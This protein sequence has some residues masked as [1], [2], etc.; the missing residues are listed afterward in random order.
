MA[1]IDQYKIRID[2]EGQQA[3]DRLKNTLG[4]L[5]GVIA[6]IGTAGFAASILKM[7][8]AVTDLADATGLA[9]KDIVAFERGLVG[10][11][12]KA[13]D[14]G[15]MIAAFYQ[16]VDKAAKGGEDA[17]NAF[18]KIG[19]SLQDLANLSEK[20][21]LAKSL[22]G[23][24]KL[25]AG[26]ER[27][28][29]GLELFG[30]A[31]RSIDPTKLE[32]ALRTGNFEDI[33]Q[34]LKRAGDMADKM[35]ANFHMLQLA[36]ANV[37]D[38]FMSTIEPFIG[39]VEEG[40]LS[41]QQAEKIIKTVGIAL[42]IAFAAK[43]VAIIADIVAVTKSLNAALKA[44]AA[45]QAGIQA[46]Q[47]PKGWAMLAGAAVAAGAAIYGINKLLDDNTDSVK[48]NAKAVEDAAQTTGPKRKVQLLTDKE[49]E[50]QRQATLQ[51]K[52]QTKALQRQNEAALAY[53]RI[54]I[55][56]IGLSQDQA[57]YI[58]QN[59]QLEID[60]Q[61]KIAD[62]E[63]KINLEK[64]KGRNTNQGLITEYQKQQD[65]IRGQ[66]IEL[67]KL[68]DTERERQLLIKDINATFD[69][70]TRFNDLETEK[71][72]NIDRINLLKLYGNEL[73]LA[74]SKLDAQYQAQQK[75]AEVTEKAR[76]LV[77]QTDVAKQ[78]Q[79]LDIL[80]QY[81]E[82]SKTFATDVLKGKAEDNVATQKQIDLQQQLFNLIDESQRAELSKILTTID[83]E[84]RRA[85]NR[86]ENTA[87]MIAAEKELQQ[88]QQAGALRALADIGKQFTPY[89]MAQ[90]A[91][92]M[93]W[94]KIGSA[95]DEFVQTGKFAFSDFA[96]SVLRDLTAMILKAQIFSAIKATLGFFG[97][98]L[99]GL[100]GGGPTVAGQPYIVGEKGPELF[101]PKEPGQVIPNNQL[102]NAASTKTPAM[103]AGAVSAPV[104]N[105][106]ITNNISALDAKSVAQIFVENRKSLLGSVN[107]AQKELPYRLA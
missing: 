61:E 48:E 10:A 57:A 9:V 15:K 79:L 45:I 105:N 42:G 98:T 40:R 59:A 87:R 47:G 62:L 21:L 89:M 75:I 71:K 12:G 27:S 35:A 34:A 24:A 23:L 8:D 51:A 64:A 68:N 100:A 38:G 81:A 32:E 36:A 106:Y 80:K 104:T 96:K 66:V 28:A 91:V 17:Q 78:V 84:N 11:G 6:G 70:T 86:L 67:K 82:E 46:L 25:P 52:E 63:S 83:L 102:N 101:I 58:A 26:A 99:P 72:Y 107:M 88:D 53:K 14:A 1:T 2:V 50:A 103:A 44:N 37:F 54:Q 29:A 60:A 94:N 16:N 90:N 41:L 49:L 4:G 56:S 92:L 13:E 73:T 19:V 18:S 22:E 97:I 65:L 93:G 77:N 85:A 95:V 69:F 3:I 76:S 5:G 30:K 39:K 33:E 7:A 20:D 31:F 55:D 74:T 43:T